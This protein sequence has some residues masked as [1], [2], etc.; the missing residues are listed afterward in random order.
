MQ[1]TQHST[2]YAST[3]SDLSSCETYSP[4]THRPPPW[5]MQGEGWWMVLSLLRPSRKLLKHVKHLLDEESSSSGPAPSDSFRPHKG[6]RGGIGNVQIIRYDTSPVGPYDEL[7]IIPS[8]FKP[9]SESIDQSPGLR[10]TQLYVSTLESVL[11][12]RRNWNT[13]KKLARF[14]FTEVE[15]CSNKIKLEVYA[16]RSFGFTPFASS[17]GWYFEPNFY[18]T[19][20]FNVIMDRHLP[21]V[22]IP[23][24]LKQLP[25]LDLP[26]L[27]PP[28]QAAD[29]LDPQSP[30]INCGMIGTS[31]WKRTS[32]TVSASTFLASILKF[33]LQLFYLHR[34]QGLK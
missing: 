5:Y 27:Q 3:K 24:K 8:A 22:N 7:L 1:E 18:E 6:F 9:P 31:E 30:E 17:T 34:N 29:P 33:P 21:S 32:H 19:P 13:P 11:N 10:I 16:L 2:I 28:L 26:L 25:M 23:V 15:G 20:F 12:G 4:F 14:E